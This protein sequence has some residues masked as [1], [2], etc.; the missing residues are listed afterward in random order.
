M[1]ETAWEGMLGP[2]P[3]GSFAESA[4]LFRREEVGGLE[5]SHCLSH[6]GASSLPEGLV[7]GASA[8]GDGVRGDPLRGGIRR[9][10]RRQVRTLMHGLVARVQD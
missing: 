5:G 2:V 7:S 6:E 3:A 9:G 10:E 8:H 1:R 4:G